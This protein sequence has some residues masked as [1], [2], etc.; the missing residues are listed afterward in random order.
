[1]R[2]SAV[3]PALDAG[4]PVLGDYDGTAGADW[5]Y[6]SFRLSDPITAR[7]AGF[8]LPEVRAAP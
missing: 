8:I 3:T 2:A 1:M 7:P 6:R 5:E 4:L